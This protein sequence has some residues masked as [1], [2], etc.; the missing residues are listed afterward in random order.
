[1]N[2]PTAAPE[3]CA[4]QTNE[5]KA[6]PKRKTL[7]SFYKKVPTEG[8]REDGLVDQISQLD[9]TPVA[10][11]IVLHDEATPAPKVPKLN[12]D[13]SVLIVERDPGLRGQIWDYPVDE[14]DRARRIYV[15]LGPY[16]NKMEDGF[17]RDCLV[18]YIEKEIAI[19]ITMDSIID[20]F[21]AVKERAVRFK[22]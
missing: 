3:P 10:A 18:L 20:D 16:Q 17:L 1:V 6:K 14:Q 11:P 7:F 9:E 5:T 22:D 4:Q 2:L 12:S 8:G 15:M 21:N 13:G 19:K